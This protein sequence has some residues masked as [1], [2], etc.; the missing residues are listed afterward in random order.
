[1]QKFYLPEFQ[2][3]KTKKKSDE[4]EFTAAP[5]VQGF[6]VTLGNSL[7]RVMIS[8]LLGTAIFAIRIEGVFQEFQNLKGVRENVLQIVL[9]FQ[10]VILATIPNT[11]KEGDIVSLKLSAQGS[12]TIKAK[13]LELPPELKLINPNLEL[14]TIVDEKVKVTIDLWAYRGRGFSSFDESKELIKTMKLSEIGIIALTANF[15]PVLSVSSHIEEIKIGERAV[16]EKLTMKVKTN[17][18]I[19]PNE[20]IANAAKIF[21]SHLSFFENLT[22]NAKLNEFNFAKKEIIKPVEKDISIAQLNFSKR[23]DNAL[24]MAGINKL[25]DLQNAELSSLRRIKNLGTKSINE[26]IEKL[27]KEYNFSFKD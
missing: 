11:L 23:T 20:A 14:F 17:S 1:M 5:L 13:H 4:F 10:K 9:N 2:I 6:A 24:Q 19:E 8:S 15:T 16:V 22:E 25:K 18:A 26:I 7:R 21:R 3:E 27:E 12:K